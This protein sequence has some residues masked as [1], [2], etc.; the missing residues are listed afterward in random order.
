MTWQNNTESNGVQSSENKTKTSRYIFFYYLLFSCPHDR[1]QKSFFLR[2]SK[3]PHFMY[4]G[5]TYVRVYIILNS[6]K[7]VCFKVIY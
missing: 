7:T 6:I 4:K 1:K 3:K 2:T 5:L